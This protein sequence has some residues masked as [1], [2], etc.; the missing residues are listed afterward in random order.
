MVTPDDVK[1]YIAAGLPCTHIEVEGD[2]QH[3]FATIVSEEFRGLTM[4]RQHQR[5]YA[6]MGDRMKAL[7]AIIAAKGS[8]AE[9]KAWF[10]ENFGP[11]FL[12][13]VPMD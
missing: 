12:E 9:L 2:G 4:I 11:G 7:S 6:A 8:E 10:T 1:N 3:F 5:V 13:D